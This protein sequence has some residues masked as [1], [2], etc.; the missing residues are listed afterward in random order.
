MSDLEWIPFKRRR[1]R[2]RPDFFRTGRNDRLNISLY[3]RAHGLSFRV[4]G[5]S[6]ICPYTTEV[7]DE[8]KTVG[9][10]VL[11]TI[12]IGLHHLEYHPAF[13]IRRFLGIKQAILQ[14]LEKH[15]N[16]KFIIKGLNISVHIVYSFEWLVLR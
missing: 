2:R 13:F 12:S 8:M 4:P 14:H 10:N 9:S 5:P 16:T 1:R 11:I 15:P 3:Y 7:I 6:A